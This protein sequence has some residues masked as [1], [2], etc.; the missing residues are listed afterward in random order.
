MLSNI[1]RYIQNCYIYRC[2]YILRDYSP[3]FLYLLSIPVHPWQHI[4]M[5]FKSMPKDKHDY[6]TVWV[7]IDRLSKQAVSMPCH[8]TVT[9]EQMA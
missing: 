5:D 4:T 1:E 2:A 8:K 3:G 6:N 7:I 9:A